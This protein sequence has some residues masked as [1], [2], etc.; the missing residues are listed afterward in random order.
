M[1]LNTFACR[2]ALSDTK[3]LHCAGGPLSDEV[4]P[5]QIQAKNYM[6]IEEI[7][8]ALTKAIWKMKMHKSHAVKANRL[9]KIL[10][11]KVKEL[12]LH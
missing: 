5:L 6:K 9:I 1:A 10:E 11:E 4:D 3:F 8:A 12:F 2:V 7:R